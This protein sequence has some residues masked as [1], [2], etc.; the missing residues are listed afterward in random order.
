MGKFASNSKVA[1]KTPPGKVVVCN[2]AGGP[3]YLQSSKLEFVSILLTSFVQ[4]QFYRSESGT[5]LRVKELMKTVDPIF[6]A[7][8]ALFARNE[9]GMRSISHVVAAEIAH[10]VKGQSWTKGFFDLVSRRADDPSEIL[11]YYMA[12]YGKP[13]PN[14]LKKGLGLALNRF[15]EYSLAKYRRESSAF[16]LVDTVNL[17]FGVKPRPLRKDGKVWVDRGLSAGLGKLLRGELAAAD[18]WETKLTQVGQNAETEE[19]KAELKSAAW[20]ELIREKKLGYLA[21][22]R[23]LRNILTGADAELIKLVCDQ[24]V[25]RE[26]I[27]KS[28]VFP[29]QINTAYEIVSG[30]S[31]GAHSRKLM[32]ALDDAIDISCDNVPR[33]DGDSVIFLDVSGSMES[34]NVA[35][36]ASIFAAVCAKAWNADVIKFSDSATYVNYN[37][38]DSTMSLARSFKYSSGGT[39]MPAAVQAMN[40]KYDRILILSDMQTWIGGN[41][42]SVL[43]AYTRKY[44]IK[45]WVY[46]FDL[47]G[48]GTMAFP[49]DRVAAIAGFSDKIF[50]VMSLL[51]QDKNAMVNTIEQVTF[52]RPPKT[53]KST[54]E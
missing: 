3:G 22:I 30:L 53:E 26:S 51:E 11:A 28:L 20:A 31:V 52:V 44:G 46:S 12:T 9:F 38:K 36:I 24:L 40:K 43:Q 18:T 14:S 23:N 1:R 49:E 25:N 15:S 48:Q 27:K 45:P 21:L 2:A 16:T 4:D 32:G 19:N 33:L 37:A 17:V 29:F 6:A 5:I 47:A 8:A 35:Q 50:K 34:A 7:K 39:N 42:N 10:A 54:E 41:T 13:I